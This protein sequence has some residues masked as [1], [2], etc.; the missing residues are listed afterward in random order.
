MSTGK[1]FTSS[2][3]QKLADLYF[4]NHNDRIYQLPVNKYNIVGDRVEETKTVIVHTFS[5]GDVE[6][7]DLYAAQPLWE[8]QESQEG[9]W[10]MENCV[11]P[12]VWHRNADLERY[13][14][15]YAITAKLM[16]PALTAW[17]LKQSK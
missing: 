5:M 8:W 6:D 10:V 9:K 14:H 2:Y 11:E 7:P 17:L 15:S 1:D 13:G 12:P 16:G 4:Q 3:N